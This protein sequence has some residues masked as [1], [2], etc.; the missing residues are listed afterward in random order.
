MICACVEGC[1]VFVVVGVLGVV[2]PVLCCELVWY[3][4]HYVT[5]CGVLQCIAALLYMLWCGH[6]YHFLISP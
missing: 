5:C 4:A 1:V 6:M 2:A 3:A